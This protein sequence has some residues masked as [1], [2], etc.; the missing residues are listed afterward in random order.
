MTEQQIEELV[1]RLQK[2]QQP[3]KSIRPI[4][5]MIAI[6]GPVFIAHLLFFKEVPLRNAEVAF[7]VLGILFGKYGTVI[8]W[9]FGNSK[10][11]DDKN[12]IEAARKL[13]EIDK[14]NNGNAQP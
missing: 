6:C 4:I 9:N 8:D 12:K 3:K 14:I 1:R 10:S 2:E 5:A 11:E 13:A 7:F